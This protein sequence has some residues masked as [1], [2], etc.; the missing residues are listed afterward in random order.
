MLKNIRYLKVGQRVIIGFIIMLLLLLVVSFNGLMNLSKLSDETTILGDT[1]LAKYYT[2]QARHDV[3]RYEN[4]PNQNVVNEV[5]GDLKEA[6]GNA[7]S[8]KSLMKS[9]SNKA[10]MTELVDKLSQFQTSFNSLVE[11]EA[12]KEVASETRAKAVA[13]A[14]DYIQ[15]IIDIQDNSLNNEKDVVGLQKSFETYKLAKQGY[16]DFI[17][18]RSEV[19]AYIGNGEDASYNAGVD[20]LTKSLD[21]FDKAKKGATDPTFGIYAKYA[22]D[23]IAVYQASLLE[24]KELSTQ[25]VDSKA[26]M[27]LSALDITT[28]AAEGEKGVGDY[29][30]QMKAK[31][32]IVVVVI[33]LL[34]ALLGIGST[35]IISQSIKKPLV[36]YIEKLNRFGKGD[37]TVHF[38][39][40]GNDEL[41]KMGHAL[42][43]MEQSLGAIIHEVISTANKFK[44]ISLEVIDRTNENNQNIESELENTLRLSSENEESLSNVSL[45]IEEISKGTVSSAEAASESVKAANATKKISEKVAVDMGAVDNEINQV[46]KQAQNISVKMQ[47]VATSVNEISTF[48]QRINEIASQTNLLALNAAIEAARAGEQGKGFSVVADEV[49]KLAEESNR[50]SNEINRI[51]KVL[52]EHSNVAL[53]EIK[54]SETSIAKVVSTTVETKNG[55]RQSLDQI[56]KLST[57]MESIASVTVEQAA[58]SEEILATSETVL[59]VTNGVVNSIGRVSEIAKSSSATTAEDLSNITQ[60]ATEMVELLSYFNLDESASNDYASN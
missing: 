30:G 3:T 15:K 18:A 46:G 53:K 57:S 45:A 42:N 29:I 33:T 37:L 1:A 23:K 60:N 31:A 22:I 27:E 12:K 26:Q 39:Q 38:D 55:M 49:R 50:A 9:K 40:S 54:A 16:E 51:I 6:I 56:E 8:A 19:N 25:Q 34:S 43:D 59:K 48:V 21:S 35:I 10:V 41:T 58:T 32:I 28:I 5:N 44:E 11:L 52:N 20:F 14:D 24:Y 4:T 2:L 17:S 36:D 47:D 7:T 13:E